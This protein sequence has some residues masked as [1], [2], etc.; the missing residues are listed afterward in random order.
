MTKFNQE[1]KLKIVL[2]YINQGFSLNYLRKKYGI[3][4]NSSISNWVKRYKTYGFKGLIVKHYHMAYSGEYKIKV[5]NW[6]HTH[7]KSYPETALHYNI[8]ASSIIFNWQ[9]RM[10][11]KGLRALYINPG[12]PKMDKEEINLNHQKVTQTNECMVKYVYAKIRLNHLKLS[13]FDCVK[14]LIKR[15]SHFSKSYILKVIHYS[16]S[17][18]YYHLKKATLSKPKSVMENEIKQIIDNHRGYGY[19]RVTATLNNSGIIVNHKR[20]Q[21]IMQ[22]KHWQCHLFSRRRRKYNSY[23]GKIG[24]IANNILHGDFSANKFGSKITTDVSE[25]RYGNCD[26]NHRVYLSAVLDLYS[27]QIIS[28]NISSHPTVEFTLKSLRAALKCLKHLPYSTIVH[29]DQGFQYQSHNW[30]NTIKQYHA[31]Q[32]MSR[33]GTCLDNAQMESFFHI[34]KSEMMN[35]HYDTKESLIQAMKVWIKDY[36]NNRIKKKLGYKSPNQYLGLIS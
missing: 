29:S 8:S 24:H 19:R 1:F 7:H 9:R 35:R 32:S 28:F 33:K 26:I 30:V 16:R 27:D 6:M 21:R 11:T 20:V 3:A 10:E 18:Y 25:F 13:I 22:K 17:L 31:I 23:K 12:R 4:S 36:N 34:M 15:L 5:L 14:I 2:E